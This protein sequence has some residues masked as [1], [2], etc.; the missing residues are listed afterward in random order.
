MSIQKI[1]TGVAM[2]LSQTSNMLYYDVPNYNGQIDMKSSYQELEMQ[3]LDE[4]GQVVEANSNIVLGHDGMY[5]NASALYR[6]SYLR[7]SRTGRTLQATNYVN[8]LSNNLEYWSKGENNIAAEALY[9][10]QGRSDSDGRVLSVFNNDYTDLNPVL[11]VPLSIIH[12]GTLGDANLLPQSADLEFRYL[13]DPTYNVFMRAVNSELYSLEAVD[14]VIYGPS[15]FENNAGA[16]TDLTASALGTVV[17]ENFKVG[18]LVRID[19]TNATLAAVTFYREV[20]AVTVDDGATIG[21][22]TVGVATPAGAVTAVTVTRIRMTINNE[23]LCEDLAATGTVLTLETATPKEVDLFV[24][25]RINVQYYDP[26]DNTAKSVLR[27]VTAL[28]YDGGDENIETVTVD[29]NIVVGGASALTQIYIQ[30]LY[31]NLDTYE[32]NVLS[33]NLVLYRRNIPM[34]NPQNMLISTFEQKNIQMIGGLDKF[35]YTFKS[36]ANGYNIYTMTPNST[37]LLS[38]AD[39]LNN[40]LYTVNEKPLTSIYIPSQSSSLHSENMLKTFANSTVYK[41]RNLQPFRD[42]DITQEVTPVLFPA[43]LFESQ[44]GGETNE[45]DFSLMDNDVKLELDAVV[46]ETTVAKNIYFFIETYKKI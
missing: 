19:A 5:Y 34:D 42:L 9:S 7:E 32:W 24:G 35:M 8:I 41:P 43:K 4:N 36:P 21:S 39:E 12:P 26:N 22:I 27:T 18:D 16:V 20:V 13:L 45:R 28:T 31:T 11:R 23:L 38:Q 3:L 14:E 30:P 10:G 25:T 15:S 44:I 6:D 46:G 33:A 40:Y 29:Q 1:P 37:N 17:G 2:P